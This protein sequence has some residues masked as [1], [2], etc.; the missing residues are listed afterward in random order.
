MRSKAKKSVSK[1]RASKRN[2]TKSKA[3]RS[4]RSSQREVD[5]VSNFTSKTSA[6]HWLMKKSKET[7]KNFDLFKAIQL[8]NKLNSKS[9]PKKSKK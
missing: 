6:A 2:L 5:S 9:K 8:A 3:A 1:S 4:T 7:T